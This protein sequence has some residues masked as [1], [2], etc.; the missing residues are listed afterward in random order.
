M[1][2]HGARRL[3]QMNANL[4]H[5]L[6]I[7][8]LCAAQGIEFRQPLKTS[9]ALQAVMRTVRQQV[10]TLIDDRILS[11]DI[12]TASNLIASGAL[13]DSAQQ[14]LPQLDN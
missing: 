3:Q 5:I 9:P 1:A 12:E 4:S 7:E 8:L 14:I 10:A 11:P 2:A 13:T 6:G